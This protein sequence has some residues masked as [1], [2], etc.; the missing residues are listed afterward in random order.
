MQKFLIVDG[1]SLIHRAFYALPPLTN[2]AGVFTNAA[3]GF[4]TMFSRILSEEKPDYVV[5]CFDFSRITFR[6][7]H[8]EAYKAHRKATPP[9]LKPQFQLVKRILTA[10]NIPYLEMVG[11]EGD[12]LIGTLTRQ[13]EAAGLENSLLTG[14]KDALQLITPQT[15]VLMTRKGISELE[16]FDQAAVRERY[17]LEPVQIIDLKGLMGDT[18]DNIPGVPGVGEKTAL[19]LLAQ[20]GTVENLLDHLEEIKPDKLREKFIVHQDLA[21]LSKKLATIA[22]DVPLDNKIEDFRFRPADDSQLLEVYRELEFKSLVKAVLDRMAAAQAAA[23]TAAK[24]ATGDQPAAES[25]AAYRLI[26]DAATLASFYQAV[27]AA[28]TTALSVLW[29]GS[30]FQGDVRSLAF[31]LPDTSRW[32]APL[33]GGDGSLQLEEFRPLLADPAIGKVVHNAKDTLVALGQASLDLAG[34]KGDVMLEAYLL[35]PSASEYSLES[36]CLESLD[37]ALLA[38]EDP[39]ADQTARAAAI[40]ALHAVNAG[41]IAEQEMEPLYL[42]V[43]LPLS[44]VLAEMEINGIRVDADQL[45]A[46]SAE[47]A[48]SI[49]TLTGEIHHLAGETF[50]IN[51]PKQLA[52]VLFEKLG[53]PP[54]KKTKTG[55]STNA[56]VLEQLAEQHEIAAKIVEHRTLAKLKS[57]YLDGMQGLINPRTSRLHTSFNQ[58]VAATGRLSSTEPNLQNI[59]VRMEIGRRIRKAFIPGQPGNVLI[60]GDYSQIELRVLAHIS[61]DPVLQEAFRQGQDIHTRTAAEVFGLPMDQVTPELRRRAKAVNFGIVYGISDYGL[62]RDLG[63]S[64]QEAK[65]YI[66]SYF[67][68]YPGVAAYLRDIV[69]AAKEQG[70]VTTLLNRRRY[71]PD[72]H[73]SNFNIRSF[74]ERTA[75]NTPIQGSAADIIKVAMVRIHRAFRDRGIRSTMLLQ[76]HDELIF[77]VPPDEVTTVSVLV[78]DLMESAFP[79]AVP[80]QVDLK[81]GPDWYSMKK[82]TPEENAHA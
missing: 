81:M 56:E 17:G 1:S 34:L 59:P 14:D 65:K 63:I 52:V 53:L 18:S 11:Y 77:D 12:D 82:M 48:A 29:Q 67:D 10:M 70:Y 4:T 33:A 41:T 37:Q 80:L 8:Y 76:V 42:E 26:R 23:Q 51:S 32:Y 7:G 6:N 35:N 31:S 3:Y 61:G 39:G 40:L 68:R 21:R 75:M 38:Q 55:Y 72:I 69:A 73:S 27:K 57:T 9:E 78:R 22:C 47:L 74:G 30:Y 2:A 19:K 71:L 13:G 16:R 44:Q 24:P 20:F 15:S 60:A 46:M 49:E 5:V 45:R 62:S 50:N 43:E 36:L 64:R 79:L 25:P 66:D 58:T 54:L 28:G